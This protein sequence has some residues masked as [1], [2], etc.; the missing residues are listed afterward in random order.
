MCLRIQDWL[1]CLWLSVY[2]EVAL[3]MVL[4]MHLSSEGST[5]AWI[6]TPMMVHT[7]DC[8]QGVPVPCWLLAKDLCSSPCGT[9]I[10]LLDCLASFP[11]TKNPGEKA[12]RTMHCLLWL[13]RAITCTKLCVRSKSN[14]ALLR[15]KGIRLHL[16]EG[17]LLDN[18]WIYFN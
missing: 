14:P 3:K 16:M 4:E 18:L 1:N 13:N 12:A 11:Q 8:C 5:W 6:S 7:H 9:L 15:R 17:A 10:G 2:N